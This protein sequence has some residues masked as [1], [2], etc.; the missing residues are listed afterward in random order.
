M[1]TS[2]KGYK[3]LRK[4]ITNP[5]QL[6]SLCHKYQLLVHLGA[7][8]INSLMYT[9]IEMSRKTSKYIDYSKFF[10]NFVEF[11]IFF[12]TLL[13]AKT[14]VKWMLVSLLK[15]KSVEFIQDFAL[16][17][18][19]YYSVGEWQ[20]GCLTNFVKNGR[21][22]WLESEINKQNKIF[23]PE[24]PDLIILFQMKGADKVLEEARKCGIP[25]VSISGVD[26]DPRVTVNLPGDGSSPLVCYTYCKLLELFINKYNKTN[27]LNNIGFDLEKMTKS[28][29]DFSNKAISLDLAQVKGDT[30]NTKKD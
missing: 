5:A 19:M 12:N 17:N 22:V 23:V 8:N 20:S 7:N 2:N 25:V 30:K 15:P 24:M 28:N 1:T 3:Y 4:N 18:K 6:H 14:T 16:R 29:L 27:S 9:Y 26:S 10:I 13:S 21:L 11:S